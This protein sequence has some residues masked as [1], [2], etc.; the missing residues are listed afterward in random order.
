[1]YHFFPGGKDEIGK[2]AI[3][4]AGPLF[5]ALID[6]TFE[7]AVD[8]RSA[9]SAFFAG[10]AANLEE[11][12]FSGG[13]PIATVA[14]EVGCTNEDLRQAT[15]EVF[16]GWVCNVASRL[17]RAGL[18]EEQARA[19]SLAIVCAF[20]G[21]FVLSRALKSAEPMRAGAL[22]ALAVF[23]AYAHHRHSGESSNRPRRTEKRS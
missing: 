13:C 20:E 12:D 4:Y 21:G 7:T 6:A 1:M 19:V 11:T 10:A 8:E 22:G 3:R 16:E 2:E 5:G 23:D 18:A 17:Q 15:A 9:I 14:L